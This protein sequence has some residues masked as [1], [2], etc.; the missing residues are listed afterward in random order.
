MEEPKE[1]LELE[2]VAKRLQAI[3][4][5]AIDGIVTI[6]HFGIIESINLAGAKMFGYAPEEILGKNISKLM[7]NP[8]REKHD[9]YIQKFIDTGKAKII[10]IGREVEGL[11]KNGN[12]FPFRLAVSQLKLADKIIFTGIIHDLTD[13]KQ[14][15][16]KLV[17][18]N[19]DL[20]SKVDART[21][22]LE[23]VVN[24]LLSTNKLLEEEISERNNVTSQLKAQEA[25]LRVALN[26][27]KELSDLKTRFVSMASHEFRTPMS[28]IL[29]SASLIGKYSLSEQQDNR[30]RH[31]ERIKS[32]VTYLTGILNDFLSLSKFEEGKIILNREKFDLLFLFEDAIE[33]VSGMLKPEQYISQSFDSCMIYTDKNIM[34][35]VMVNLLSN[36]IKY[37]DSG[38]EIKCVLINK[39]EQ[40]ELIIKD[41]GLG[42][43]EK[44]QKYLFDRFFRASNA[45]NLEGTGLGLNLVRNYLNLM[46]GSI[47]FDSK[48][49]EGTTFTVTLPLTT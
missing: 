6:D 19:H 43:P 21:S 31:V 2:N 46:E 15:E 13:L 14:A 41:Q 22:Q 25:E 4:D 1:I 39:G 27:E 30:I 17:D 34:K 35:N 8:H 26:K 49:N 28:T 38:S 42:I 10:G 20:E 40:G 47:S 44:E 37:S 33:E 12:K 5:T 32:S 24:Q 18:L 11:K 7:P 9:G 23:N 36:A 3:I 16:K 45:F 48:L 29:S